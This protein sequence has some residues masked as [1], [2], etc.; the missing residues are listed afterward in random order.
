[1]KTGWME[2]DGIQHCFVQHSLSEK[3]ESL[4]S[5]YGTRA[6]LGIVSPRPRCLLRCA[7]CARRESSILAR[8]AELPLRTREVS[9][10][11]GLGEGGS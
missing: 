9:Q 6:R 11:A 4:C 5:R 7:R 1:M 8:C 3:S 10:I 2:I